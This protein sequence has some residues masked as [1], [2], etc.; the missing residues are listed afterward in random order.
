MSNLTGQQIQNT[1]KGLLN[2]QDSTTG[3]TSSYQQIQDG[4]GNN[5]N[6][7]ISTQGILSPNIVNINNLKPDY[8]GNGFT[9][10]TGTAHIANTQNRVIYLPFYDPGVFSF[11]AI[12]YNLGT[13]SST[14]DVVNVAFYTMQQVPLVGIAP[15]DLIMSGI[16]FDSVAPST[17]GVKTSLLPSTLSFSGT[18]GGFYIIAF[19]ISNSGV[20]PTVRYGSPN[21]Q[22]ANQAYAYNLGFYLNVAGTGTGVGQR[23]N[24]FA[25]QAPVLN[26]LQFQ[27]S[28]SEADIS[29][30]ISTTV[31]GTGIG[32]G[33]KTI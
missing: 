22:I 3:I 17:T 9:S 33:L 32:F 19:Y 28:Y 7:R 6:T 12:S 23:L 25:A 1:Y 21:I 11:S 20:T 16:T 14:S 24:T 2:L 5:T 10:G 15:K 29:T 30:N 18:G 4:L 26:N 13:L 8:V 31:T 27:T